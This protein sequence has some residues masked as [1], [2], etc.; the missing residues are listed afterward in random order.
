MLVDIRGDEIAPSNEDPSFERGAAF[1]A[2]L[3]TIGPEAAGTAF[4][5]MNPEQRQQVLADL[6]VL[7]Q[8]LREIWNTLDVWNQ[9]DIEDNKP[10]PENN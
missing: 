2:E 4:L 7:M 9:R 6:F 5:K 1:L 8:F 3:M 10:Q